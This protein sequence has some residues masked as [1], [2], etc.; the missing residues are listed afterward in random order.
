MSKGGIDEFLKALFASEGGG[1]IGIENK[2]GYIGKYQF[3]EDALID[4][5][6]YTA[7]GSKNRTEA[8]K[9]KYDWIG[10]WTGKNGATSKDVF[11]KSEAIQDMAARDWV[12]LLCKRM[13]RYKLAQYIGETMGGVEVTESGII[14][15]AHLKGFGSK[16]HP[17]VNQFLRSDGATNGADAF[18]TSVSKYMNKFK[19]YD[20]GCCNHVVVN[21]LDREKAP[22][23]GLAYEIRNGKK[24]VRKG[25]TDAKGLTKKIAVP[26][27][28]SAYQVFVQRVEG[29][30]KQVADFAA[31]LTS[32][33]VTLISPK[34]KVEAKLEKHAG[35]PG[36]YKA[37]KAAKD[38][39][40]TVKGK[41]K[42]T[43]ARG[44]TGKPVAVAHAAPAG[45]KLSGASWEAQFPTSRSL[46]DLVPAFKGKVAKFIAAL[47]AGGATV[48]IS[49]TYRPKE[50][51]YMMHYC[52]KIA[53]GQIAADKVPPMAGVDIDWVHRDAKGDMDVAKSRAAAR[54][55]MAAYAIA[56]PAALNSRHT[57]KRAIDMTIGQWVGKTIVDGAGED[58]KIDTAAELHALGKTFGVIKLVKDRPHWSDDGH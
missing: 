4:L 38:K 52:C 57:Q 29:G 43:P 8:D 3:G 7:D 30:M 58:T 25:T 34:V 13:K 9:F 41:A 24:V 39:S 49:A 42:T 51:A 55:M 26:P 35:A 15:A 20:L 44:A 11:L 46:D 10:S 22:I 37:G 47:K 32:A 18:G 2:F 19:D 28:S 1:Q 21:V 50:R 53:G 17:G 33:L 31:P 54:A 27:E 36:A 16:K 5:G 45:G 23:A 56:F 40:A 6:Y 12:A 14:A 48:R